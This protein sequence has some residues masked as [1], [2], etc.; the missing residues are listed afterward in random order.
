MDRRPRKKTFD[1]HYVWSTCFTFKVTLSFFLLLV[2]N[3]IV[4]ASD[5]ATR[6]TQVLVTIVTNH[7][8]FSIASADVDAVMNCEVCSIV[9]TIASFGP[10]QMVSHSNL[11]IFVSIQWFYGQ[12]VTIVET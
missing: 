6:D 11:A 2:H 9:S 10:L 4:Y 3:G 1:L 7:H 12:F 8:A 5:L